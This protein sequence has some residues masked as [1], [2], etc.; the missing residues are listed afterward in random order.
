MSINRKLVADKK[1]LTQEVAELKSQAIEKNNQMNELFDKWV[2]ADQRSKSLE[3]EVLGFAERVLDF[4]PKVFYKAIEK[5]SSWFV[6]M[7]D[8]KFNLGL[9]EEQENAPQRDTKGIE[10]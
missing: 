10:R 8:R 2:E 6:K 5:A 9:S 3:K 1:A 4:A 7:L